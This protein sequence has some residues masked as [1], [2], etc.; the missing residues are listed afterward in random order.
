[1]Y[2]TAGTER[3]KESYLLDDHLFLITYGC[4]SVAEMYAI[5]RASGGH[6]DAD[7]KRFV[8]SCRYEY[9]Q[10]QPRNTPR[11][12]SIPASTRS[13]PKTRRDIPHLLFN[14]VLL[15]F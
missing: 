8:T 13:Q 6:P 1:M 3:Q 2:Q 12:V 7:E 11:P 15:H 4:A 9:L 14:S 10:G 5:S